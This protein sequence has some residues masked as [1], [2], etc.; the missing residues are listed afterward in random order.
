ME[1]EIDSKSYTIKPWALILGGSSGLGLA[2]A[3]KLAREGFN[4]WIVHRDR[5]SEREK[6]ELEFQKIRKHCPH[7]ITQNKDALHPDRMSQCIGE[8]LKSYPEIRIRIL[9]FSIAKGNVKSLLGENI[10]TL[11]DFSLTADAMAFALFSWTDKLRQLHL[12]ASP[13]SVVAFTSEGSRKSWPGYAAVGAA[14]AALESLI[15]SM[16]LE[17]ASLGLRCNCIQSGVCKTP[18]SQMIPGFEQLLEESRKRNPFKRLT[19]PEDV[20]NAVYLLSREEARWINGT[21]IPV[22]GGESIR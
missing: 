19:Q 18:S 21:I 4:L 9:V 20:A 14:K 2:T 6:I 10:L 5:A 7:L 1:G 3:H 17:Y 8:V 13:G 12:W 11:N 15:R 22:D 16:A